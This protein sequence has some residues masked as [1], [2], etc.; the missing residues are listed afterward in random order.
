[1]DLSCHNH[2]FV[3]FVKTKT[4]RQIRPNGYQTNP[5]INPFKT[6]HLLSVFRSPRSPRRDLRKRSQRGK[7]LIYFSQRNYDIFY[8]SEINWS[9]FSSSIVRWAEPV[10]R[11]EA[12]LSSFKQPETN[13]C[14]LSNPSYRID[15]VSKINKIQ[16]FLHRSHPAF[17][18]QR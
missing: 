4:S 16:K 14:S 3:K 8:F 12:I 13:S 10:L 18:T 5:H 1:M 15:Q 7:V 17:Q 2:V 11:R 6:F 9:S